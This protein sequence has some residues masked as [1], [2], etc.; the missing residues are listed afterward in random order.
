[1]ISGGYN[2]VIGELVNMIRKKKKSGIGIISILVMCI[3]GVVLFKKVELNKQCSKAQEKIEILE[4]KIADEEEK[5][6]E[7]EHLAAYT[8]TQGYIE[9]VAREKLGLIYE[10]EIIILPKE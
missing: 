4:N 3:C 2:N 5:S 6:L 8:Q 1:M 7:I 10:D 9:E